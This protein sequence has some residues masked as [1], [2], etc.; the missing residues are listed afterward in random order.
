MKCRFIVLYLFCLLELLTGMS[1]AMEQDMGFDSKSE[2]QEECITV[3]FESEEKQ[4]NVPSRL[5]EQSGTCK[6]Q[7]DDL[8]IAEFIFSKNAPV[9]VKD[10]K[11]IEPLL[12]ILAAQM[13]DDVKKYRLEKKLEDGTVQELASLYATA[14]FLDVPL[15]EDV[16]GDEYFELDQR[17]VNEL[18]NADDVGGKMAQWFGGGNLFDSIQ[19]KIAQQIKQKLPFFETVPVEIIETKIPV[20]DNIQE[21]LDCLSPDGKYLLY[22]NG[23]TMVAISAAQTGKHIKTFSGHT[24]E[25]DFVRFSPGGTYIVSVSADHTMRLWEVATGECIKVFSYKEWLAYNEICFSSDDAY[26]FF[27]AD[28][29]QT[30]F[31]IAAGNIIQTFQC[32]KQAQVACFSPDNKY[33]IFVYNN[34][35]NEKIKIWDIETKKFIK[36]FSNTREIN[37]I[38]F[39][40]NGKYI[41]AVSAYHCMDPFSQNAKKLT[42]NFWDIETGNC[43]ETDYKQPINMSCFSSNGRCIALISGYTIE[44]WDIK[45][46]KCIKRLVG[47]KNPVESVYFSF[48]DTYLVSTDETTIKIWDVETGKCI[49]EHFNHIKDNP[50]I[51]EEMKGAFF[52]PDGNYVIFA[53]NKVIKLWDIKSL[54]AKHD[55][56]KSLK[57]AQTL[58]LYALEKKLITMQNINANKVLNNIF[59]SLANNVQKQYDPRSKFKKLCIQAKQSL[60]HVTTISHNIAGALAPVAYN[61]YKYGTVSPYLLR[62]YPKIHKNL[63]V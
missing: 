11:A 5:L 12:N 54:L 32:N 18:C 8:E 39:C 13:T 17:M 15:I 22:R 42:I 16:M 28:G 21:Y 1:N 38:R 51:T 14:D 50:V 52:S 57:L 4:F 6:N 46:S 58:L 49:K 7:L 30:I 48:D 43:I 3:K 36:T 23:G 34:V 53:S 9:T 56:F 47:H 25:V 19:V 27:N 26:I 37:C 20:K 24:A 44:L 31:N 45:T 59:N 60:S 33:I 2:E 41:A 55:E 29:C 63:K 40:C 61:V 62:A 10:F 35:Y